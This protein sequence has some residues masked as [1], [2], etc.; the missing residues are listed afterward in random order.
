M[1][2][3]SPTLLCNLLHANKR[4]DEYYIGMGWTLNIGKRHIVIVLLFSGQV[5]TIPI[6][7]RTSFC[8]FAWKFFTLKTK[9]H[10]L[11]ICTGCYF[12][13]FIF[14]RDTSFFSI[15]TF[16]LHHTGT[17]LTTYATYTNFNY[18]HNSS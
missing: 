5:L 15:W 1:A 2:K 11:C 3:N 4:V 16:I 17:F 13:K 14:F 12:T 8:Y 6:T 18:V 9:P 7:Y 10:F